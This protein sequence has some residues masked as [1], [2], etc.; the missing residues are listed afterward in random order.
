MSIL[1]PDGRPIPG[2]GRALTSTVE[3]DEVTVSI[4]D[5]TATANPKRVLIEM[6][7][8]ERNG[9]SHKQIITHWQ[10]FGD[11]TSPFVLN[12]AL[13]IGHAYLNEAIRRGQVPEDSKIDDPIDWSQVRLDDDDM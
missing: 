13:K 9:W 10:L 12:R 5:D 8:A 3:R 4:G 11:A 6:A 2:H 1:G 7:R